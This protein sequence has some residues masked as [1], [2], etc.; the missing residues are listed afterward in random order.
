VPSKDNLSA[1]YQAA[2]SPSP[3]LLYFENR[4]HRHW[5]Y[6]FYLGGIGGKTA[7]PAAGMRQGRSYNGNGALLIH[8]GTGDMQGQCF[9]WTS[10][11][12]SLGENNFLQGGSH[13]LYT[14]DDTLYSDNEFGDN[15]DAY[16]IRCVRME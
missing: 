4:G 5:E 7:W 2:K 14:K 10:S 3:S 9:Y 1:L 16:P 12:V 11:Q 6:F 8:S 15:A 13:R